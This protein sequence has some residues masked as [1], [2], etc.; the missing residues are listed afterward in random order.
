MPPHIDDRF[1][2]VS[3]VEASPTGVLDRLVKQKL[4]D[5][6]DV[7]RLNGGYVDHPPPTAAVA[8][9]EAAVHSA[10]LARYTANAGLP[11]LR[12]EIT[13][14]YGEL[15]IPVEQEE[16]IVTNGAKHAIS[17][18]LGLI[19]D[20]GDEVILPTPHWPTFPAAV[21]LAG[22]VPV[23]AP[24]VEGPGSPVSIPALDAAA[25]DRTKAVILVTPDNPSGRCADS[26]EIDGICDWAYRRGVWVILDQTYAGL[27]YGST[28]AVR[29]QHTRRHRNLVR[30]GAISKTF[31]LPGWRIG[32]LTGTRELIAAGCAVQ[33]HTVSHAS[34]VA[35]MGAVG[36][37]QERAS[38]V[39][40][41]LKELRNRRDGVCAEL[42]DIDGVRLD[43]PSGGIYAFADVR[44]SLERL[45]YASTREFAERVLET[46]R[47]AVLPGEAFGAPGWLR[48]SFGGREKANAIA[49][50]RLRAALTG[51]EQE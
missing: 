47:V 18:A 10:E 21:S 38:F 48:L 36:A 13:A 6:I 32:W 50:D 42:E 15:G 2:I 30:V 26:A 7:A 29:R 5:G 19:L 12:A 31:C 34:N 46:H 8:A 33:S 14:W 44:Q 22:G 9:V 41:L 25:T 27:E 16:I 40:P 43:R 28:D 20:R 24:S 1:R 39:P 11:R 45:M 35:Q 17:L 4:A 51:R 3:R 23:P 49:S 37:L